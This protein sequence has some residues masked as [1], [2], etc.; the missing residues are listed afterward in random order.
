MLWLTI[1]IPFVSA[2]T[3]FGDAAGDMVAE[4]VSPQS[5][6]WILCGS[7]CV[8]MVSLIISFPS[9]IFL[10]DDMSLNVPRGAVHRMDL[11]HD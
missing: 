7:Y 1:H 9:G 2:L 5:I 6:R 11:R 8:A 10:R 4:E 3:L